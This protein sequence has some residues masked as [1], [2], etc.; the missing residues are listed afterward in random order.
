MWLP[1]HLAS[2]LPDRLGDL[3]YSLRDPTT[4]EQRGRLAVALYST[5]F[6]EAVVP[7]GRFYYRVVL[8]EP[9]NPIGA[10]TVRRE[11]RSSRSV[12]HVDSFTDLVVDS[13]D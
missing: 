5:G 12:D 13:L 1:A 3:R 8:R 6:V 2:G 7:D 11:L 9:H 10:E 4:S